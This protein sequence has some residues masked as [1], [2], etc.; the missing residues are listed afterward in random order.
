[1]FTVKVG[2]F[3]LLFFVCAPA[4]AEDATTALLER[5]GRADCAPS[6]LT[7]GRW[8]ISTGPVG[9]HGEL[10]WG[11][12][13]VFEQL[14]R[15][16]GYDSRA[17]FAIWKNGIPWRSTEGWSGS[18]VR[19]GSTSLYVVTGTVQLNGCLHE[20]AVGRMDHDDALS[21]RIEVIFAHAENA[22]KCADGHQ[23]DAVRHP[24]HAHGEN[25]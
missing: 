23:G 15:A 17:P 6:S 10:N 22:T 13:L 1:M 4:H 19:D 11:D 9:T 16:S 14:D 25:D 20:L 12:D 2:L 24:G 5:L 18:C 21:N 8:R 3:S 7:E